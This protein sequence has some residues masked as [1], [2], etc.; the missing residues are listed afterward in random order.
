MTFSEKMTAIANK[1]RTLSGTSGALGLDAMATNIENANTEIGEQAEIIEQIITGLSN[2]VSGVENLDEEIST[3][4][5]L[6]EQIQT[7]LEGKVVPGGGGVDTPDTLTLNTCTLH[8]TNNS[9]TSVGQFIS[10]T[11]LGE[12]NIITN[13]KDNQNNT[14]TNVLCNSICIIT[15]RAFGAF[16]GTITIDG[17]EYFPNS[18][19]HHTFIVPNKSSVEILI[20]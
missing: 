14:I 17:E 10:A 16:N 8:I 6:I 2:K 9:A 3:Q 18:D 20:Q 12:T 5:T 13:T 11:C 4:D 7:A 19:Y 1:I 15:P